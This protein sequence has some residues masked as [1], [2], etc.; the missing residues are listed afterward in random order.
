MTDWSVRQTSDCTIDAMAIALPLVWDL[1][2]I[3]SNYA[4]NPAK[5]P[6]RSIFYLALL[7]LRRHV[8]SFA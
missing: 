4:V 6:N 1:L 5:C 8:G 2:M 3:V 7:R